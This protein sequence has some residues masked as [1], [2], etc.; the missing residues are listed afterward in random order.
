MNNDKP[1]AR[2]RI[3]AF[4]YG[5]LLLEVAGFAVIGTWAG[6]LATVA[7]TAATAVAGLYLV[8]LQ[9]GGLHERFAAAFR[10]REP[11]V[12]EAVEGLALAA[13]GLMLLAPGFITDFV[14]ALLLVPPLRRAAAQWLC[15]RLTPRPGVVIDGTWRHLSP[16]AP[17]PTHTD[18]DP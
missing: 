13:A 11:P 1:A 6:A 14:G 15:R 9:A 7:V 5:L 4:I 10:R 3:P 18:N 2:V 16:N 17:P 12:L 8:R